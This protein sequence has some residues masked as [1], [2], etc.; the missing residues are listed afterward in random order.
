M[1]RPPR[2]RTEGVRVALAPLLIVALGGCHFIGDLAGAAAA[3][4]ANPAVGIAVGGHE[5]R[6]CR[7]QQCC[8]FLSNPP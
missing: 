3:A 7:G 5:V 2:T 8:N 1:R 4:R 6:V